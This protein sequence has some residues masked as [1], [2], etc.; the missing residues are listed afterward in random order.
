MQHHRPTSRRGAARILRAGV[1]GVALVV[2][3]AA[4]ACGKSS[5][6]TTDTTTTDLAGGASTGACANGSFD[7]QL[8]GVP[9]GLKQSGPGS[10]AGWYVWMTGT[11]LHV[12]VVSDPAKPLAP[13]PTPP[14]T[15]YSRR[16]R[17]TVPVT[18]AY[19]GELRSTAR[20]GRLTDVPAPSVGLIVESVSRV[21]FALN[22]QATPVGFDVVVPCGA[23]SLQLELNLPAV[24][25]PGPA[26]VDTIFLGHDSHPLNNP[27]VMS[28]VPDPNAT[29]TTNAPAKANTTTTKAPAKANTT[30][31]AVHATTSITAKP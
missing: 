14:P 15:A 31:T 18:T 2:L 4:T 3:L 8:Q 6:D 21:T 23:K 1:V 27:V 11:V 13:V 22:G 20:L 26:T 25:K 9:H 28:R 17:P 7:S 29:T 5:S 10:P 30:T 16:P 24:G 19:T 12:R